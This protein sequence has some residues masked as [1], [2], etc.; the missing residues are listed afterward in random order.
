[1]TA[2]RRIQLRRTKGWRLPPGAVKV[3]RA[4]RWGNPHPVGEPCRHCA[5]RV[6]DRD[7]AIALYREHLA[8]HPELVEAARRDLAGKVLACWCR[9]DQPCHADVLLEVANGAA[10]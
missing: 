4:T 8:A 6:H 3:D 10:S 7:Q 9:L 5:G 2:P 1:M